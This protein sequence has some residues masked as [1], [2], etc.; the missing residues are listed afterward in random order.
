M[1]GY[2]RP[3]I[4][5]LK[6]SEHNFYKSI[7]CGLCYDLN[8]RFGKSSTFLLN[9]DFVFLSLLK[10]SLSDDT[11]TVEQKRCVVNKLN[12]KQ[13]LIDHC[14]ENISPI[15]ILALRY[16]FKDNLMDKGFKD[17]VIAN[18]YK[19]LNSLHYKKVPDS[20][21]EI[22][23]S[24]QKLMTSQTEVENNLSNSFDRASDPSATNLQF[25]FSQLSSDVTTQKVLARMGYFI[26]RWVYLI[27]ALDDLDDDLKKGN[28]NTL[29]QKYNITTLDKEIFEK[30]WLDYEPVLNLTIGEIVSCYNLL[31]V[32]QFKPILDNIIFL[33][34]TQ[35]QQSIR[36]KRGLA[37]E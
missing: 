36:T 14:F 19:P 24:F 25:V 27:D 17:K 13:M 16:K 37:Y 2:I 33:G 15:Y 35:T 6:V 32:K 8:K 20:F 12:K 31:P 28:Y 26:G 29:I 18:I 10:L 21:S 9:Y 34:L 4:P 23:D 11:V 1:F 30:I 5:E 3:M 22:D 7:Y